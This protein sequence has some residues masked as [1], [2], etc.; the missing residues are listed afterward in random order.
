M[1]TFTT[2]VQK[3]FD[4]LAETIFSAL[5]E[6]EAVS[7]SLHGEDTDF[8]RMNSNKIRQTTHVQQLQLSM[9]LQ[10]EG[11]TLQYSWPL[12]LNADY[13]RQQ[14]LLY[15]NRA[16]AEILSLP[17]DPHQIEFMQPSK[18]SQD[19]Q[20]EYPQSQEL[21][22]R[23]VESASGLDLA[24]FYC[25]GPVIA[26]RKNNK[27]MSHWFSSNSFFMDYSVYKGDKAVK[28]CYAGSVWKDPE[29]LACLQQSK[30]QLSLMDRPV[31]AVSPGSY[32]VYLAPAAV[33]EILGTLSWM[34]LGQKLYKQGVS[35]FQ[36]L[37]QKQVSLSPQF[38]LQENF[39]LGLNTRFNDRGELSQNIVPLI[40]KG[41]LQ[42]FL[43]SSRSAKEYNVPSN[44]ANESERPRSLEILPGNLA[45]TDILKKLG[46]G[47][48]LSNLHYINFSDQM[49]ARI[50]GMTRYA[51]F[52][53]ENGEIVGPIKDMRFDVSLYDLWGPH[54]EQ[55]TD[56]QEID[57]SVD[58]YFH[59][60]IGGKKVPGLLARD[61][62]FTL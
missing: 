61:F 29:W 38:S 35:P 2:K 17:Q 14:S 37:A 10:S 60:D 22:P 27:G 25:S 59:R 18:S 47:L 9:L 44:F 4:Q 8:V 42:Q 28:N 31:R 20:G 46:T 45:K 30:N 13:D 5:K 58:T 43:T 55:L 50:T 34:A 51:C 36:K 39:N 53:V 23:I 54:L 52:W 57:P 41:V 15:L 6:Q 1:S 32:R 40:D 48:Y 62:K 12:T 24:G 26:A 19:F 49:S 3:H 16:R 33:S 11:K 56:F 7:L 21:I